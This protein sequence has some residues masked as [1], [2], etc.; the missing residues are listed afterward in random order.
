MRFLLLYEISLYYTIHYYAFTIIYQ[1]PPKYHVGHNFALRF[2]LLNYQYMTIPFCR[3][4]AVAR[5]SNDCFLVY[6]IAQKA[7][8]PYG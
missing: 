1:N 7:Y 2:L 6:I 3:F 5:S 4:S 8:Q